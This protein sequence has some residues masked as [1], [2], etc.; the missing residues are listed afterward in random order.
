ML[1]KV[2]VKIIDGIEIAFVGLHKINSIPNAHNI[3]IPQV[4]LTTSMYQYTR[5]LTYIEINTTIKQGI[6]E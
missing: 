4:K 2:D 3:F 5:K 6:A 1:H